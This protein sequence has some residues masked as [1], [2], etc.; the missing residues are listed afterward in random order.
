MT[1]R[2]VSSSWKR[3]PPSTTITCPDGKRT[4]APSPWP[5]SRNVTSSEAPAPH[6]GTP[7]SHGRTRNIS[8]PPPTREREPQ[9]AACDGGHRRRRDV[10][11]RQRPVGERVD[12]PLQ[13]VEHRGVERGERQGRQGPR[14]RRPRRTR[15]PAGPRARPPAG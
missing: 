1:V 6:R 3:L 5:T 8:A 9:I 10:D 7:T 4:T 13:E 12:R 15:G 2:P 14:R 11:D